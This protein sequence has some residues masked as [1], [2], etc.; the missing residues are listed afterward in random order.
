MALISSLGLPVAMQWIITCKIDLHVK[1]INYWEHI[2][3]LLE[4]TL[5]FVGPMLRIFHL[6]FGIGHN[7]NICLH[8]LK[9]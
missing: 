5:Y 7:L 9:F 4:L 1:G 3:L 6:T 2:G 8:G